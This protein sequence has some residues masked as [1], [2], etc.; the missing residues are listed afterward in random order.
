MSS[1][2][3]VLQNGTV[4]EGNS[5]GSTE[6]VSG[7][8]VFTTAAAGYQEQITDPSYEG[9]V[10]MFTY[11]LVGDYGC[12]D[13]YSESSRA[14]AKAVVV[15]ECSQHPSQMYRGETLDKFL[16]DNGVTGISGI[17][18]RE[19]ALE[20]REKGTMFCSIVHS[21]SKVSAEIKKL[22]SMSEEKNLVSEVSSKSQKKIN[23]KKK[24]TV[25]VFDL[26][27]KKSL[28][29]ELSSRF[30]VVV[31]PYD[32]DSSL[33]SKIKADGIV[34]SSGPGNPKDSDLDS[35]TKTIKDS[36]VPVFGVGLGCELIALAFGADTDKMK[37]GHHGGN[38]PVIING[39][40]LMTSQNHCFE[41]TEKSLKNSDLEKSYTNL[42]DGTIEG[43][44]H[45]KLPIFGTMFTPGGDTSF[46]FDDFG[47]TMGAKE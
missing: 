30:N 28:L 37:F 26:G 43:I 27:L 36:S 38:Q 14:H 12:I 46:L 6:D 34:I 23:S 39:K 3:L 7:E 4:L 40:I 24:K 42:S 31:L 2:F 20:I 13:D 8:L 21:E 19:I 41:I 45:K 9:Q 35:V 17:D 15:R 22:K 47:K 29:E 16:K 10:L 32:S 18:T 1:I 5:F 33:V 44:R 11:P 25:A